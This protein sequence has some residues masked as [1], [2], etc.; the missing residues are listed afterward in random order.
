M[1][2]C[3]VAIAYSIVSFLGL[4]KVIERDQLFV[5]NMKILPTWGHRSMII[6]SS[7]LLFCLLISSL[8]GNLPYTVKKMIHYQRRK[9]KGIYMW[10]GRASC[11]PGT[12]VAG[13]LLSDMSQDVIGAPG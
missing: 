11:T 1:T 4:W 8:F 7:L 3:D 13:S 2:I 9:E 12:G 6:S 5:G 10:V